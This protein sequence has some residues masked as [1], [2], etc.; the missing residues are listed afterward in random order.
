M[1][2]QSQN[3]NPVSDLQQGLTMMRMS[4]VRTLNLNL[5]NSTTNMNTIYGTWK[6]NCKLNSTLLNWL[7]CILTSTLE[8]NYL[9]QP[10]KS[11]PGPGL[12]SRLT[13]EPYLRM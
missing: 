3:T 8:R 6:L 2:P 9:F 10:M 12:F 4:H 7:N 5:V 1:P 13:C 11:F